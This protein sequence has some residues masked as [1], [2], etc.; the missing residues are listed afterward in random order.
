MRPLTPRHFKPMPATPSKQNSLRVH[1]RSNQAKL[2]N[3]AIIPSRS[4]VLDLA[5]HIS[6]A[7]LCSLQVSRNGQLLHRPLGRVK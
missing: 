4:D 1:N 3:Q 6:F 2:P 7:W 5:G